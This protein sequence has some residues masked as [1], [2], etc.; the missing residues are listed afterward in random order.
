MSILVAY[1]SKHGSTESIAGRIAA[2]LRMVGCEV[3]LRP[4]EEVRQPEA[5]EAVVLGSAVYFG[6]WMKQ[7]AEFVRR[8]QASLDRV[9]VWLF[10]V[11]P[12]GTT[13]D[14]RQPDP[15]EIA[16][17]QPMIHPREH[18]LFFGVLDRSR[19]SLPERLVAQAVKAPEG[20]FRDWDDIETWAM[21]IAHQFADIQTVPHG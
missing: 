21:G 1:S 14:Q 10:S 4:V 18:H 8:H 17:F 7:A 12:L 6:S 2:R 16:E 20:D 5:Y 19:L 11:G 15:K 13:K 9:P 3:D